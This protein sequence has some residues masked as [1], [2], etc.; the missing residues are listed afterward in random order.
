[1]WQAGSCWGC[2]S[3]FPGFP[4]REPHRGASWHPATL[5]S[6]CCHPGPK[7]CF[8]PPCQLSTGRG[9]TGRVPGWAKQPLYTPGFCC[10]AAAGDTQSVWSGAAWTIPWGATGA[11][12]SGGRFHP[13]QHPAGSASPSELPM[14]LLGPAMHARC[15]RGIAVGPC[16]GTPGDTGQ[17]VRDRG[18]WLAACQRLL[19]PGGRF[20]SR[21]HPRSIPGA[22]HTVNHGP[23]VLSPGW[24]MQGGGCRSAQR[25]EGLP[26]R[27]E[28]SASQSG[29]ALNPS[30]PSS[31]ARNFSR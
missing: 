20:L 6:P 18:G 3:A 15:T 27:L 7:Q 5:P 28:A 17:A 29:S 10:P 13:L 9:R 19:H 4:L 12:C 8:P 31:L 26:L 23:G 16:L 11:G 14:L 24:C 1:M 2:H 21:D 30:L 25:A 22:G